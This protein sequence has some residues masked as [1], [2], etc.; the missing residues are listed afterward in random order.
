MG[1]VRAA[2]SP[3]GQRSRPYGQ[4]A[5]IYDVVH[6][7]KPYGKEARRVRELVRATARRPGRT[8]LDVACGSGRHL[9][10]FRR[11]FRVQG[12]DASPEMLALARKR[13]PRIP[14]T[15]GRMESFDLHREFDVVTCL[16]SA[17]G[18]ARSA[19]ELRAICTN[20]ARHTAPGGVVVIEPWLEPKAFRRGNVF[21][22]VAKAPGVTVARMDVSWVRRGRSIF[23]FDYLIGQL[24]R[25]ERA[26]EF[27]DLG[28]FSRQT[29]TAALRAAGLRPRFR[30]V[31]LTGSR[32]LYLA[33]RPTR[34]VL[35]ERSGRSPSA[36]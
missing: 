13:L 32:G 26:T 27:H 15:L 2:P 36:P 12:V 17:I 1:P 14:L 11:W 16:F 35:K 30:R 3:N 6:A 18:Y 7:E 22:L 33:V 9:A 31:G 8:L 25:I 34:S 21:A 23:R 4:L 24:S 10:E 29:M 5:E 19:S 28:L 20:L